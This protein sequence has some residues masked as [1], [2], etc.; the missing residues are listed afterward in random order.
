MMVDVRSV[1]KLRKCVRDEEQV[2]HAESQCQEWKYLHITHT[3]FHITPRQ[4]TA[5]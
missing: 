1:G 4:N 2:V 5:S 3:F